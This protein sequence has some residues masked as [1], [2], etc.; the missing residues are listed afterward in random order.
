MNSLSDKIYRIPHSR[1]TSWALSLDKRTNRTTGNLKDIIDLENN[2]FPELPIKSKKNQDVQ[3]VSSFLKIFDQTSINNNEERYT[4]TNTNSSL[5]KGWIEITKDNCRQQ[6]P[7]KHKS[8]D[9][10]LK[11][12][13]DPFIYRMLCQERYI[14]SL[15]DEQYTILANQTMNTVVDIYQRQAIEFIDMHGHEYY[16]RIYGYTPVYD[17][18]V[19]RRYK[20][21]SS[22]ELDITSLFEYYNESYTDDDETYNDEEE[23]QEFDEYDDE[24]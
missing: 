24:Y 4:Y 22:G 9:Q 8:E 23:Q 2:H 10:I 11:E 14:H 18:K 19:I 15:N 20:Y 17:T 6:K 12:T 1:N 7:N 5:E 3:N 21:N 13:K 16:D